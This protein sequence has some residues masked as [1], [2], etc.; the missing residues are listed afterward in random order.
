MEKFKFALFSIVVLVLLGLVLYWSVNTIQSGTEHKTSE[1][2]E[3]LENENEGLKKER[4]EL[5]TELG[6]LQLKME[7]KE[8][9]AKPNISTTIS[10]PVTIYKNQGLINELQKLVDDNIIIKLKSRGTRVGTLQKFLNI[11]K[12]TSNKIDNDFGASTETTL[13]TFQKEQ[14]STADGEAGAETFKKMIDWLKKKG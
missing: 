11:Y 2:I 1:Q 12:N 6:L 5:K 9:E 14:G 7:D 3:Q 13:K 8:I 10:A 4:D